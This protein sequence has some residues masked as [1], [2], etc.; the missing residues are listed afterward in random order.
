MW[1]RKRKNIGKAYMWRVLM[2]HFKHTTTHMH[3]IISDHLGKKQFFFSFTSFRSDEYSDGWHFHSFVVL[4]Q[5][6]QCDCGCVM[7][8]CVRE[9]VCGHLNISCA[10]NFHT[11]TL[12]I[13][14]NMRI[15]RKRK[16]SSSMA[17]ALTNRNH[18]QNHRDLQTCPLV[19]ESQLISFDLNSTF[20]R[21]SKLVLWRDFDTVTHARTHMHSERYAGTQSSTEFAICFRTCSN[22]Y[23]QTLAIAYRPLIPL[24]VLPLNKSNQPIE[25]IETHSH[26]RP[27]ACP[28]IR[29]HTHNT[30]AQTQ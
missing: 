26:T 12:Y 24:V 27:Q 19:W 9:C 23:L 4:G 15:V 21:H 30:Y 28:S 11:S 20:L 14:W 1:R 2:R 13:F 10:A 8:G 6:Y 5:W 22:D 25:L 17:L 3:I 16:A 29:T 18:W 7:C